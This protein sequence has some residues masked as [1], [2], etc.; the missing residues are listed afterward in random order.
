MAVKYTTNKDIKKKHFFN[1]YNI[2]L[3]KYEQ[4]NYLTQNDLAEGWIQILPKNS[5]KNINHFNVT[6]A[7][8]PEHLWYKLHKYTKNGEDIYKVIKDGVTRYTIDESNQDFIMINLFNEIHKI[9]PSCELIKNYINQLDE[10]Q[11]NSWL[12]IRA[13]NYLFHNKFFTKENYVTEMIEYK[14]HE[15]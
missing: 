6:L 15:T 3:Q 8:L 7:F 10:S 13:N 2:E 12:V 1:V 14:M 4:V 5:K 9:K 11:Y